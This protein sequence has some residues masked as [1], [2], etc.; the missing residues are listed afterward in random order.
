[1]A[2]VGTALS[3]GCAGSD[4]TA[5]SKESGEDRFG[6]EHWDSERAAP[7]EITATIV[8][9]ELNPYG[10][11]VVR[12]DNGQIW[13]QLK[14]EKVKVTLGDKVTIVRGQFKS[15]FFKFNDGNRKYRFTRVK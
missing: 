3:C 14:N 8:A 2:G 13:K 6:K 12:L 4:A 5:P 7:E 15:F 11:A 1:M 9:A 10:K